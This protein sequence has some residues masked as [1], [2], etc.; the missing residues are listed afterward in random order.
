MIANIIVRSVFK[1][2]Q[3]TYRKTTIVSRSF[4]GW[5]VRVIL[6]IILGEK[7]G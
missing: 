3:Y 5:I 2:K 7:A 1:K 4:E 6:G